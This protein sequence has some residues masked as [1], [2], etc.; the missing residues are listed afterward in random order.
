LVGTCSREHYV[1]WLQRK[2]T[3]HAR[4]DRRRG[5]PDA[6]IS[7]YKEA[8]HEAVLSGGDSDAYT[9]ERYCQVEAL[10]GRLRR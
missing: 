8:I 4:R 9:G 5:N 7:E 1:R 10:T 6:R 2:A 3:A